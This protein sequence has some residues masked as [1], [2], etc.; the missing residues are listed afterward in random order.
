MAVAQPGFIVPTTIPGWPSPPVGLYETCSA[1]LVAA[2]FPSAIHHEP[3]GFWVSDVPTVNATMAAYVGGSSELAF[4]KAQKQAAL[5]V[6]FDASFDLK[7]FIRA[8]TSTTVAAA[9]V[10][11]FLAQI[12]N[13]YR[14]LRASIAAAAN[15][16]AVNAININSG[17]PG[18][19]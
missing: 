4:T 16:A 6:L 12:T 8:G 15:V 10:G 18:N 9:G 5:D 11:T 3:S 14:S 1:A 13:N 19:P 7:A 17:W 2:G